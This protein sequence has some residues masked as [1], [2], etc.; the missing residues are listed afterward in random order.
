[1]S[2]LEL[3]FLDA[4]I[5]LQESI[6]LVEPHQYAFDRHLFQLALVVPTKYNFFWLLIFMQF[7]IAITR[8][9][10]RSNWSMND[11]AIWSSHCSIMHT[12]A[13][14]IIIWFN[15]C[16]FLQF[17]TSLCESFLSHRQFL[18]LSID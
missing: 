17:V 16:L 15:S 9:S 18:F 6:L 4:A 5:L 8:K 3:S 11:C 1:M 13:R 12:G 10:Y 7:F 2:K 14:L